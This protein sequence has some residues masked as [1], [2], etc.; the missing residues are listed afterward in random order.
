MGD[1]NKILNKYIRK[2]EA[3]IKKEKKLQ[4]DIAKLDEKPI[5]K[6]QPKKAKDWWK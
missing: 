1:A 6:K 2:Q 3:Y 4:R 5:W